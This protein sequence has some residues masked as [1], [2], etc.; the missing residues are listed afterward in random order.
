[1]ADTPDT[2]HIAGRNPVREALERQ[3]ASIEKVLLQKGTGGRAVGEIRKAASAA[4]VPV[5]YV[6]APAL[7]RLVPGTNHQGVVA[8]AAPVAYAD[9]DDMLRAIAPTRD[10]VRARKPLLV[11]LD[12]IE[13]PY[14]FGAVLRSVVAAGADGVI[15]PTRH[16]APLNAA[17][18]KA[19]AGTAL[20][21]P[22]ARVPNLAD[23]INQ[24]KERGYWV[25]GAAGDGETSAW[26]MD[27]DRPLALVIGSE[28]R[29]MGTRVADLCDYRVHIPMPGPAESLNAS[30]AAGILLFEAVR[31]RTQGAS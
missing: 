1:M 30:V 22:V 15:V 11:L 12:R 4:G 5:Q 17:A 27:W 10:D 14:N 23:L 16:M 6:P 21:V 18:V 8:V 2:S 3:D 26:A 25:A 24:L 31:R 9:V 28:D 20:R 29:G 13:D 19:S 7:D